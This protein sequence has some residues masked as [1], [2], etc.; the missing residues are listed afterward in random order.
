MN[1]AGRYTGCICKST[2]GHDKDTYYIILDDTNGIKVA[3][4][5]LKTVKSPKHKNIRHVEIIDYK[6]ELIVQKIIEQRVRDEDI[7]YSIKQFLN[8]TKN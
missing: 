5:R 7:K 2:A 3:D 4:G 8:H 6:D 1:M